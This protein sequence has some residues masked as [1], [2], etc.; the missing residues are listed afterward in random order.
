MK[1]TIYATIAFAALLPTAAMAQSAIDA[2]NITPTEL[3]GSARFVSMGGAFTS[4]GGDISCMTQ[5]PAGLGIYRSSDIGLSFDITM[6]KYKSEANGGIDKNSETGAKFDNFGYVGVSNRSGAL[7]AIQW[8]VSYNRLASFDRLSSGYVN[9][10]NTSLS[11]YIASYT[12]GTDS[13]D[14]ILENGY[15]PFTDSDADWLSALAYNSY[16]ISNDISDTSYAGL[17]RGSAVGDAEYSIRER[18]YSDEYNIDFSGN[19]SDMFFWGIG[20]GI[21]DMQY[22]RDAGYNESIENGYVYDTRNDRLS[23]GNAFFDLYNYQH[24]SG[25]GANLKFGVIV[26]PIEMLR[27]GAAIHTPTWMHLVHS[28]FSGVDYTYTPNNNANLTYSGNVETPNYEYTSKLNTPWRFMLGASVVLGTKAIISADYERVAYNN[29]SL[30]EQSYGRWG[31]YVENSYANSDIKDY[32]K[33]ADIFRVGAELRLLPSLSVRAGYNIQMSA[34]KEGVRNAN[35]TTMIY[36]SGTEPSYTFYN[37]TQNIT[38]GLGY[39]YRSW[40]I[41]AAFQHTTQS[42]TYHAYTPFAG[43]GHTPSANITNTYNNIVISTGIRF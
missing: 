6:R 38:V 5:N 40:Y 3:R 31:G 24:I 2:Y 36:T 30:K 13:Y 18:G 29:M 42:G 4:L 43:A 35:S 28:G 39:R 15:N 27:V 21:V 8:G 7:R 1:T 33:A 12:N 32:F 11:N 20:L 17:H 41:D 26:R 22:S 23:N 10:T 25:T 37:D 9:P 16:M 14:L 34:V 19:V